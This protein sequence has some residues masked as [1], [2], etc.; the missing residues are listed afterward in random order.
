MFP[1]P[2][3]LLIHT[4][5][6]VSVTEDLLCGSDRLTSIEYSMEVPPRVTFNWPWALP[7]SPN[8]TSVNTST[9]S[10]HQPSEP[11]GIETVCIVTEVSQNLAHIYICLR[12]NCGT[13]DNISKKT[14]ELVSRYPLSS[15][16]WFK[17]FYLV[18]IERKQFVKIGLNLLL[19]VSEVTSL[20]TAVLYASI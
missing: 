20:I 8:V 16:K 15:E 18:K 5:G 10:S 2:E 9:L 4:S 3:L 19:L 6:T 7:A 17:C 12:N 14:L 11:V 13:Q 1:Y